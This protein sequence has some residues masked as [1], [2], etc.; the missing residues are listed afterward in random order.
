VLVISFVVIV[1]GAIT[2]MVAGAV[3]PRLRIDAARVI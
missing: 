2:D 1:V 3:D